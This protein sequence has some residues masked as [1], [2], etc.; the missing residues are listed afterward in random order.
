MGYTP[1]SAEGEMVDAGQLPF[2]ADWRAVHTPGHSPGQC[3][4]YNEHQGVLLTGDAVMRLIG[5]KVRAPHD[6]LTSDVPAAH[7]SVR[8]LAELDF[9][10][11][12]FGHGSPLLS[13]ADIR[14]RALAASLPVP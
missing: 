1:T 2:A 11:V 6:F 5:R 10:V 8:R 9:S 3:A 13:D 14:I 7:A 12:G 4:L